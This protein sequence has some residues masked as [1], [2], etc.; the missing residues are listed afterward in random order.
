MQ[1]SD[2]YVLDYDLLSSQLLT[3][4]TEENMSLSFD[5]MLSKCSEFFNCLTVTESQAKHIEYDM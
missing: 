5:D 1:Y 2:A 4:S 3:C